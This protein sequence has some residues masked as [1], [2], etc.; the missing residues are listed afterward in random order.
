MKQKK[1]LGVILL[2]ML[3]LALIAARPAWLTANQL[4]ILFQVGS[5]RGDRYTF[6][7]KVSQ[8]GCVMAK[9]TGWSSSNRSTVPARELALILNGSNRPGYYARNDGPASTNAPLWISYAVSAQD[10]KSV[11]TWTVSVVNFTGSGTAQGTLSLEV[12]P[13]QIPCEFTALAGRTRGSVNL[14]WRHTGSSFTG[15]FLVERSINGLTWSTVKSCTKSTTGATY[16]CSD[17]GHISG[18]VYYYRACAIGSS[19]R[20]CS[21]AVRVQVP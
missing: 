21:P 11:G 6:D 16:T 8:A 13:T 15:A 7:F 3:G 10:I 14:S 12:P 2:V 9:I 20:K 18:A 4:P 17:S 1:V 19:L 5:T